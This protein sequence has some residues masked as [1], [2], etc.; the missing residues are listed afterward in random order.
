MNFN[1][2]ARRCFGEAS[3]A[4]LVPR[5]AI[6]L[7]TLLSMC[8]STA[9]CEVQLCQPSL[10]SVPIASHIAAPLQTSPSHSP[11][12]RG[13][14]S[15][16]MWLQGEDRDYKWVVYVLSFWFSLLGGIIFALVALT[17]IVHIVVYLLVSPPLHPFLNSMF[18]ALDD[19]FR[20][21]GIAAF[22]L[23]C[24]FLILA[25]I[26]G[27]TKLGLN[28]GFIQLYPMKACF[29]G[30]VLCGMLRRCV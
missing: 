12:R 6:M 29:C 8:V 11:A 26:K 7:V 18:E 30:C 3:W 16:P 5:R 27:F 21:F 19:A 28:F 20:L 25:A 23:W 4:G 14:Q 24:F 15:I 9:A 10:S 2:L 22:A 1:T 17:W 13:H